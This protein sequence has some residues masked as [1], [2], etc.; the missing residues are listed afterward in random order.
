MNRVLVDSGINWIGKIPSTWNIVPIKRIEELINGFSFES[1]KYTDNGYFITRITN[2][3]DGELNKRD[4]KYYPIEL[5]DS[6]NSAILKPNDVLISLTGNVG[7]VGF[8]NDDYLPAALNQRVGSLRSKSEDICQKYLFYF[9]QTKQFET[10]AIL[11]SVGTAQLNM[12]TNWLKE[13]KV[14]LPSKDE[15]MKIASYLEEKC[16]KINNVIEDNKKEIN[17]LEEYKQSM[18]DQTINDIHNYEN[19]RIKNI[20]Y[21]KGRIGWQGLRADEFIDEGPYLVTGTD[22]VDGKVCWETCYHISDERYEEAKEIQLKE[23]DLL[24]T[25]DGTIGKLA[26]IDFLPGKTSL[27]SH[28]LVVRPLNEEKYTNKY[29]YWVLKSTDFIRY[30][31]IKSLGSIMESITQET[32]LNYKLKLPKLE[33]Q[34]EIALK[35]EHFCSKLDQVITYRKQIIEKLNEYKKTL[36]YECVTGKKEVN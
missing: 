31:K 11:N 2:V 30:Y 22:F 21:V 14:C 18:I 25:K 15:Q 9:L 29:L 13:V 27:N 33:Q 28:L 35:L 10:Q 24:I 26:Y 5:L 17:L 8:V 12:S 23:K 6:F 34:E 16:L 3:D 7:L 36:I 1:S 20:C 19:V 32:F 4:P